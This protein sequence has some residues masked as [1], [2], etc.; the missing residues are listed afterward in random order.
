MTTT[1][2]AQIL[3]FYLFLFFFIQN[4]YPI[5]HRMMNNDGH[6]EKENDL[7]LIGN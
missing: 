5:D 4:I 3:A 2:T 1:T 7:L 6:I